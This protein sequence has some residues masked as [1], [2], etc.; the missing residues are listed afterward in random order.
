LLQTIIQQDAHTYAH[1]LKL[2]AL[3]RISVPLLTLT[4]HILFRFCDSCCGGCK[5]MERAGAIIKDFQLA[6]CGQ[7]FLHF[8]WIS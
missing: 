8:E 2:M 5:S 4:G 7:D 3:F 6:R 1:Q